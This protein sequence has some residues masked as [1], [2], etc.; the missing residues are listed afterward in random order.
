ME[1]SENKFKVCVTGFRGLSAKYDDREDK[2][3]LP[4]AADA[5]GSGQSDREG[6]VAH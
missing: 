3:E 5:R 1:S 4:T 6:A 2:C